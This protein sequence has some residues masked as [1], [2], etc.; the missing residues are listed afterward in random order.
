VEVEVEVEVV[1]E[2][3]VALNIKALKVQE[4]DK[5]PVL[6]EEGEIEDIELTLDL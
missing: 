5:I 1:E 2:V 3:V 4:L 6:Q